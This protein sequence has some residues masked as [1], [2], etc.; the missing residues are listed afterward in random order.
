MKKVE[1]AILNEMKMGP[2]GIMCFLALLTQKG[3]NISCMSDLLDLFDKNTLEPKI[4]KS[5]LPLP[6]GSIKRHTPITVAIVGASRRFLSQARTHSVGIDFVSA[7]L[8]YSNYSGKADFYVPYEYIEK[9]PE[10]VDM[11]LTKCRE[12]RSFYETLMDLD[13]DNDTAGYS[14]PQG[15]RNILIATAN[16]EAWL[17][18][19]RTRTCKRNTDEA[20][21][22]TAKIW[23]LLVK[24]SE[25]GED[26]FSLAGPDCMYGK[27]REGHMSCG[28]PIWLNTYSE[29]N[30]ATAFIKEQWPKLEVLNED[31]N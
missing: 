15:L 19:I 18:F 4:T 27:C 20:K 3:H 28:Q 7:S 13:I 1:V 8:Q 24:H 9:G 30:C 2:A 31:N 21:F 22:V 12:D 5:L 26:M 29:K 16:H 11:Y 14:M 17:N 6:H 25:D 10:Y 23:E